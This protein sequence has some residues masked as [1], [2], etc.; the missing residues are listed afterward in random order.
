MRPIPLKLREKMSQ[1]P[2]Y[3]R[4]C[5]NDYECDGT[6]QW[7]HAIEVSGRQIDEEWSI[8]P[9]CKHHHDHTNKE[10]IDRLQLI[11]L[12]RAT[13]EELKGIS[14]AIDLIQRRTYLRDKYNAPGSVGI[15]SALGGGKGE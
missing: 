6:V 3:S 9:A 5:I 2:Y 10:Y 11:A 12:E 7:H 4:C 15:Y 14:K 1:D 13:V 8:V